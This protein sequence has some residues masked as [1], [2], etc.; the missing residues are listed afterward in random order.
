M[1]ARPTDRRAQAE[2][3]FELIDVGDI[4]SRSRA[5]PSF[6]PAI[7]EAHRAD[8]LEQTLQ[9]PPQQSA[10]AMAGQG[11]QVCIASCTART[12]LSRRTGLLV[13]LNTVLFACPTSTIPKCR[14]AQRSFVPSLDADRTCQAPIIAGR[15]G[16]GLGARQPPST[17]L[18][19]VAFGGA[20]R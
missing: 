9:H 2:W 11:R 16:V 7:I 18:P 1:L 20:S 19:S 17:S 8:G 4:D 10:A 3:T 14:P 6:T 15:R 13:A 5:G 12:S